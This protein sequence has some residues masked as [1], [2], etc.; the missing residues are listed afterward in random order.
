MD[1]ANTFGNQMWTPEYQQKVE[2]MKQ[3]QDKRDELNDLEEIPIV[4][5]QER[6]YYQPEAMGFTQ[7]EQ[8]P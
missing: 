4:T 7:A 1:K 6:R 5:Q 3:L 2:E 8:Q